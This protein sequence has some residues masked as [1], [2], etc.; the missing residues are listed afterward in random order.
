MLKAILYECQI[1]RF[2]DLVWFWNGVKINLHLIAQFTIKIAKQS[3]IN[4]ITLTKQSYVWWYAL[5]IV[6]W[7]LGFYASYVFYVPNLFVIVSVCVLLYFG[8]EKRKRGDF[9][10]YSVFNPH[11]QRLLGTFTATD[12]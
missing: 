2:E 6:L 9:S 10:A 3:I 11:I 7:C 5:Y 4:T 1:V 8:F 12:V